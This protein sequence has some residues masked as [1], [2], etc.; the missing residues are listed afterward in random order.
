MYF[1]FVFQ[2]K[3]VPLKVVAPS[4]ASIG[5]PENPFFCSSTFDKQNI[6]IGQNEIKIYKK[7]LESILG[8]IGSGKK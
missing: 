2:L 6:G 8:L 1:L 3:V 7:K 5:H 4:A